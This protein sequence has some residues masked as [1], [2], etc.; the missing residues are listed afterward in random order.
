[1][2]ATTPLRPPPMPVAKDSPAAM[3]RDPRADKTDREIL[4]EVVGHT[5]VIR[6]AWPK[7]E[8]LVLAH[9]AEL[10]SHARRLDRHGARLV[11]VEEKL[12]KIVFVVGDSQRSGSEAPALP[13]MR[14]PAESFSDF[15]R[16]ITRNGTE[17]LRGTPEQ[18]Q[19]LIDARVAWTLKENERNSDAATTQAVRLTFKKGLSLGSVTAVAG[20]VTGL[21]AL[22]WLALKTYI[23]KAI[24]H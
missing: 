9:E 2:A 19:S 3:P 13:P 11:V 21:L 8:A 20:A 14:P 17:H 1:M 16:E 12:E 5:A 24:G 23:D 7:F 15:E 10:Q 18:M 4:L 6:Q 22:I